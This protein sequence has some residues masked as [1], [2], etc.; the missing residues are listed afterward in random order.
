MITDL[1]DL[2]LEEDEKFNTSNDTFL[3]IQKSEEL[4]TNNLQNAENITGKLKDIIN[5]GKVNDEVISLSIEEINKS[6]EEL[7]NME[8][9]IMRYIEE[10]SSLES[11]IHKK[12]EDFYLPELQN[13][14]T[15]I[16][17]KMSNIQTYSI[18]ISEQY[19]K[20]RYNRTMNEKKE[21]SYK[22]MIHEQMGWKELKN[23]WKNRQIE[24]DQ[25]YKQLLNLNEY[26]EDRFKSLNTEYN[27]LIENKNRVIIN[28]QNLEMLLE[29]SKKEIEEKL[30]GLIKEDNLIA[31][32]I[33]KSNKTI[34][35]QEVELKVIKS[36]INESVHS[37]EIL[38]K[39]RSA[40]ENYLEN[41]LLSIKEK[42]TILLKINEIYA[43]EKLKAEKLVEYSKESELTI[44]EIKKLEVQ[45]Q[46]AKDNYENIKNREV[47][48]LSNSEGIIELHHIERANA[49][50]MEEIHILEQ[51]II[52]YETSIRMEAEKIIEKKDISS[53]KDTSSIINTITEVIEKKE[54]EMDKDLLGYFSSTNEKGI[55]E[56]DIKEYITKI[57]SILIKEAMKG[58]VGNL[59]RNKA[60]SMRNMEKLLVESLTLLQKID[61]EEAQNEQDFK[62]DSLQQI[63]MQYKLESSQPCNNNRRLLT[64]TKVSKKSIDT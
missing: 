31:D 20:Q 45:L 1:P 48:D 51:N 64:P 22:L 12:F 62:N 30:N 58:K 53:V 11:S 60:E 34:E 41:V 47:E 37:L 29:V 18:R 57:N 40:K 6:I 25:R 21:K 9:Q 49:E 14:Q 7:K 43:L 59:K 28:K 56:Q 46:N 27:N 15:I 36:S 63:L 4:A 8:C 16:A 19:E 44:Q 3:G 17:N 38:E 33:I 61:E 42:D 10:Q 26:I 13:K 5:L 24:Y 35:N 52:S 39:N 54:K 23:Y 2:F 55:S 50:L 32:K